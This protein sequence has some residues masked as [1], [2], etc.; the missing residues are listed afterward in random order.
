MLAKWKIIERFRESPCERALFALLAGYVASLLIV[1]PF[2]NF[3]LLDDWVYARAALLTASAHSLTF[4]GYE[5]AW[6]VP[7][8]VVGGLVTG[9]FGVSHVLLRAIGVL[10]LIGFLLVFNVYLGCAKIS[11]PVRWIA[12]A[13]FVSNPVVYLLSMTFMSD[14]PFLLLWTSACFMWDC[15]LQNKRN[16]KI[17]VMAVVLTVLA[18]AQRQFAAFIPLSIVFLVIYRL[19]ASPKESMRSRGVSAPLLGVVMTLVASGGLYLWIRGKGNYQ[20]PLIWGNPFTYFMVTNF[21]M[22]AFLGLALLSLSIVSF[23][24]RP[25]G[26][27][28]K[29]TGVF[30][31]LVVGCLSLTYILRGESIL[32]GNLLSEWGI[33]R[34]DEVLLGERPKIFGLVLNGAA[35]LLVTIVVSL[36]LSRLLSA[37]EAIVFSEGGVFRFGSVLVVA[38]LLYLTMFA[39]RGGFDR[40]L[41][42][43]MPGLAFAFA[44]SCARNSRFLVRLAYIALVVSSFFS[45]SLAHDYFR[46]NEVKWAAANRL[47]IQ[48]VAPAKIHAG[49]EWHGWHNGESSPFPAALGPQ[50]SYVVAFSGS[51]EGWEIMTEDGWLSIW[52]P[53]DRRIYGLRALSER[54]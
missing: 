18:I 23:G 43:A 17:L 30:V 3:P 5:S 48:G 12:C 13:L 29:R 41:L 54:K 44:V 1:R 21:K 39:L 37:M 11:N 25:V 34:P 16:T 35:G 32:F 51:Y 49:Y 46:W 24:S 8:V 52:P 26:G 31:S 27:S 36:S 53:M 47:V 22:I 40:Y 9:L 45:F 33:L 6:V 38:T 15:A 2:G 50:Y 14:V 4:T 20:P 42:P 28:Y 10:S 19:V 7:Q